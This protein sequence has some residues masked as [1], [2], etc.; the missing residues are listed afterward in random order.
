MVL[1]VNDLGNHGFGGPKRFE[2]R[3]AITVRSV[4]DPP[5]V[6]LPSLLPAWAL[7]YAALHSDAGNGT[8]FGGDPSGDLRRD[9][10]GGDTS[11]L[12]GGASDRHLPFVVALEDASGSLGVDGGGSKPFAFN[13]FVSAT[14]VSD[15][16]TEGLNPLGVLSLDAITVVDADVA[17]Q[18]LPGRV[19]LKGTATFPNSLFSRWLAN[20]REVAS[21]AK[22]GTAGGDKG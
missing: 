13:G 6:R 5:L 1:T 12:P 4:N 19:L 16:S 14:T 10:G 22:G 17:S 2:R 11:G 20:A 18:M 15:G 8:R 21:S 9:L 7:P 3:V